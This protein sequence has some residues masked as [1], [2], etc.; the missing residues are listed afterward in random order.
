MATLSIFLLASVGIFINFTVN[1]FPLFQPDWC[2]AVI[3][4]A[5]LAHRVF[6]LWSIPVI[7]AHDL[8]LYWSIWITPPLILIYP[9]IISQMDYKLGPGQPQRFIWLLI[10][11]APLLLNQWHPIS[12][13]LTLLLAIYTWHICSKYDFQ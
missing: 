5:T 3:V 2:L 6:A 1:S 8:I 12:A 9:I 13:I 11:T 4:G 7:I 10:F